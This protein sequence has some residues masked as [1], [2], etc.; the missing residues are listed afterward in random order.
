MNHDFPEPDVPNE[1]VFSP[2]ERLVFKPKEDITVSRWAALHRHVAKGPA[3]GRW[4]NDLTPY[5]VEPM[6]TFNLPWIRKIYLC[7][8]PQTGKTQVALNCLQFII[9]QAPGPAMY[10]MSAEQTAKR[11]SRRQIIPSFKASPR[12]SALLSDKVDDV[13]TKAVSFKNGM[14]L[15]MAWATSAAEMA[16]ESI[17]YLFL[18]EPGKYPDFAGREADPF[19][20]AEIRTNAYPHT[21][22]I[23]YFSTPNVE[24]DAFSNALEDDVDVTY[25]YHARCPFCQTHQLMEFDSIHWGGHRDYRTIQRKKLAFYTCTTCGMDWNDAYR[26]D[27]VKDGIW[28]PDKDITRPASV[29]FHLP[30]WYSPFVSLSDVAE[31]FLK[32]LQDPKKMQAFVTQHKA[33]PWKEVIEQKDEKKILSLKT[34]LAS[35]VVPMGTVALTAGIDMQ[36][37]GFWFVVRAWMSDLTS[38]LVH[39]GSLSH[40]SDVETLV[41][42]TRYPVE[43]SNET[44]GIWRAGIDTGGGQTDFDDWSRTEEAYQW[45]RKIPKGVVFGIKGA[46]R[47]QLQRVRKTIIDKWPGKNRPMP[48]GLE[49]RLIDTAQFKGIIHWRITRKEGE[50]QR[51]TLNA[52]TGIDYASQILSEELRKG[53]KGTIEWKR[54]R[55]DNHL[56]DAEVYA[57]ACAD[58]EWTPSLAFL[59]K[60]E[61]KDAVPVKKNRNENA[62]T[63]GRSRPGWYANR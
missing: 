57:A 47:Q 60:N 14:D 18:D 8:A 4:S 36:K 38:H 11:I 42:G 20:L 10:I 33:E 27:A 5:L 52:D 54:I 24:G 61:K 1:I 35:G 34:E 28:V 58:G 41:F 40:W 19:S 9:D 17:R 26:D 39:Y 50:T 49:L 30:S 62:Q 7:F 51:F 6:D 44:M 3:I 48:G 12:I 22:K 43:G 25:R 63:E 23:M 46:S 32:G 45:L 55:K 37:V 56:L 53:R 29:A 21:K 16:S 13:S 31:A 2:H 15:M 59:A